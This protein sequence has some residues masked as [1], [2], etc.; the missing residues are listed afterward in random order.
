M[1]S[2]KRAAW[3]LVAVVAL[4]LSNWSL[5][6]VARHW[7]VPWVLSLPVSAVFDGVALI[8]ASLA[9]RA[10]RDGDSTFA[11]SAALVIFG[12][13]SAWFNAWHAQLAGYPLAAMIFYAFPPL[14]AVTVTELEL[15]AGQREARRE[16]GRIADPLPAFGGAIW[17]H[18]PWAA[19]TGQ[20]EI[21]DYRLNRKVRAATQDR[22]PARAVQ[23]Q[24]GGAEPRPERTR[25][26][27]TS[28]GKREQLSAAELA[29]LAERIRA[30]QP[31][32]RRKVATRYG[33]SVHNAG[34]ALK[35]LNGSA[36]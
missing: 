19:W 4:G 25:Q 9:L 29:E 36:G 3:V 1:G 10:A 14:A 35:L 34:Q 27:A 33:V 30:D 6:Y 16:H 18:H 31:G 22:Q 13:A 15:R 23:A 28:R 12:G 7:G 2:M 32:G 11:P 24:A 8:C 5:A 17:F 21:T 26:P 20:H